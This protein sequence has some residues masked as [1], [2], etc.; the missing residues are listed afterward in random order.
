M[1]EER[2]REIE[3]AGVVCPVPLVRPPA[4]R[5]VNLV[6]LVFG[7]NR[8]GA[9][10]AEIAVSAVKHP[11]VPPGIPLPL[12]AF[13][14]AR[15]RRNPK[16]LVEHKVVRFDDEIILAILAPELSATL[17]KLP[18]FIPL[19]IFALNAFIFQSPYD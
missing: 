13:G 12:P 6:R 1:L 10:A 16:L 14:T 4:R 2:P 15:R 7:V 9:L 17:T 5:A 8:D 3:I 11:F 18:M 19:L